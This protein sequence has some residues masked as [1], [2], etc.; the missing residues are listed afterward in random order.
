MTTGELLDR[1]EAAASFLD[2]QAPREHSTPWL[3]HRD[4]IREALALL[5]EGTPHEGARNE[6]RVDETGALDDVVVDNPATFRMERMGDDH[7][8]GAVYHRDGTRTTFDIHLVAVDPLR[9]GDMPRLRCRIAVPRASQ[10]SQ[11]CLRGTWGG[12]APVKQIVILALIYGSLTASA[13]S[14]SVGATG[15]AIWW[16][17]QWLFSVAL[18][19]TSVVCTAMT[20]NASLAGETQ[21]PR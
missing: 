1:L 9:A 19:V 20:E 5:V 2:D 6:W 4:T 17:G 15:W 13:L 10:Y 16:G 21:E 11:S 3:I 12:T 18:F 14:A 8:W 7:V